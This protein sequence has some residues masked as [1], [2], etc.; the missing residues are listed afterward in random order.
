VAAAIAAQGHAASFLPLD[1]TDEAA[2]ARA[3]DTI[4]KAHGALDILINNAGIGHVGT[5]ETTAGADL[6][7]L[8]SVNVRGIFNVSKAFIGPM[9]AR[10]SGVIVNTASI[11]G[12]L[13]LKDRLAYVTT[14]F[15]AVGITKAMAMDHALEGIRVNC[16]CPGR[17]E[18][19]WIAE[20]LKS[21][22]DPEAAY[23]E[24]ASSQA[25]GRMGRPEEIAAAVL[26]L[27]SDEASFVTGCAFAIDGGLSAGK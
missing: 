26:Y 7:R 12:L 4:A 20:R 11:A 14:K 8:Y 2:C 15:A 3:A 6:D 16:V 21:Y 23:R 13:A 17:V 27:A 1:V 22:P 24:M 5:I 25:N 19:P 10:K 9:R 18:T